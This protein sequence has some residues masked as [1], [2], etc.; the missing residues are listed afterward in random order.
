MGQL[1]VDH[2]VAIDP[3]E[4]RSEHRAVAETGR[5]LAWKYKALG[6]LSLYHDATSLAHASLS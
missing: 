2:T 4:R 5:I 6:R 3:A 1:A